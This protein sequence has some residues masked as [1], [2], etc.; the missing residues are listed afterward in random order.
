MKRLGTE[1]DWTSSYRGAMHAILYSVSV[2]TESNQSLAVTE[3][4]SSAAG[5]DYG[6]TIRD[7][8]A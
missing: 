3:F 7:G 6:Y 8:L 1:R 4:S 5:L 2:V